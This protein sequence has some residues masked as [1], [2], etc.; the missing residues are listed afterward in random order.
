MSVEWNLL[1]FGLIA[2]IGAALFGVACVMRLKGKG[3]SLQVLLAA[4]SLAAIVVGGIISFFH[5]NMPSRVF[6]LLQNPSSGISLELIFTAVTLIAIVVWVALVKKNASESAVKAVSVLGVVL[7]VVFPCLTGYVYFVM[8]ARPAWSIVFLPMMYFA[9]AWAG[10]LLLAL[11][12]ACLKKANAD[13][14]RGLV[15][16]SVAALGVFAVFVVLYL[17]GLVLAPMP[18]YSRSVEIVLMGDHAG[19]FWVGVVVVAC[20]IPLALMLA[21]SKKLKPLP[22]AGSLAAVVPF[23]VA[24][25]ACFVAGSVALRMIVYLLGTSVHAYIY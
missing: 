25:F 5:L 9:A 13:L 15:R 12:I 14:A 2:G 21:M 8:Y 22:A 3:S 16:A 10:A 23:A 11:L 6:F 4:V 1:F 19:L 20:A 18:D 24:A 17:V 7:A